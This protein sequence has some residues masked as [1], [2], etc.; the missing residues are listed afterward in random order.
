MRTNWQ[1]MIAYWKSKR[2]EL[3][4]RPQQSSK[5]S[6]KLRAKGC[7]AKDDKKTRIVGERL[8]PELGLNT[9]KQ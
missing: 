9:P 4:H 7:G 3:E 2:L 1:E 8:S 5:R 6:T